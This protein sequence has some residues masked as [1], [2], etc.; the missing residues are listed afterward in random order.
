MKQRPADA[1]LTIEWPKGHAENRLSMSPNSLRFR[2]ERSFPV[3][4]RVL[5]MRNGRTVF[6]VAQ[7]G[8]ADTDWRFDHDLSAPRIPSTQTL[9]L[10]SGRPGLPAIWR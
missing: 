3:V 1:P 4:L 10:R 8:H 9:L 2:H 6:W 5:T 7:G